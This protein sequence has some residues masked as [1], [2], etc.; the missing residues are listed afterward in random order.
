[1]HDALHY[2]TSFKAKRAAIKRKKIKIG[3][4]N[5]VQ[6]RQSSVDDVRRCSTCTEELLIVTCFEVL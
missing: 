4:S 5:S 6:S 3:C 2:N 1:M